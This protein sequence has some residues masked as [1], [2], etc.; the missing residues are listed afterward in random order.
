MFTIKIVIVKGFILGIDKI[1]RDN[2]H[3]KITL[4]K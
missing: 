4:K 3:I 2:I 1:D